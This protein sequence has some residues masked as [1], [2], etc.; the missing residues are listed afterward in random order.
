[1]QNYTPSKYNQQVEVVRGSNSMY[2]PEYRTE[3]FSEIPST[4]STYKNTEVIREPTY[5]ERPA[6]YVNQ[7]VVYDRPA[8]YVR[9]QVYERPVEYVREQVY[10]RPVEYVESRGIEVNRRNEYIP[11]QNYQNVEI[12]EPA[13]RLF[14][15]QIIPSYS[16][17]TNNYANEY[18]GE[19]PNFELYNSKIRSAT[20]YNN[21]NTAYNNNAY[22]VRN[23]A[24]RGTMSR[25]TIVD[26]RPS[27]PSATRYE[28]V[29]SDVRPSSYSSANR[30]ETVA[31]S[32]GISGLSG[33]KNSGMESMRDRPIPSG[34]NTTNTTSYNTTTN[35]PTSTT[36][37]DYLSP[38]SRNVRKGTGST[39]VYY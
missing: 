38:N 7:Q 33:Q 4:Y 15:S 11:S 32:G 9:E 31:S 24:T 21:N 29:V 26:V 13:G 22:E 17:Y 34:F 30:Y 37:M 16:N 10:D 23:T 39:D 19:Q 5:F 2:Q 28:T 14:N 18:A 25:S 35:Y 20:S 6:E 8:E 1:V 27:Y 36:T 3:A 12:R